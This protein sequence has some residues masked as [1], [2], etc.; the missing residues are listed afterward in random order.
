MDS[1]LNTLSDHVHQVETRFN[2]LRD[3]IISK[4]YECSDCIKSTKQL[5]HETTERNKILENKL[6]NASYEEQEWKDFKAKLAKTSANGMIILNV[7]GEK[8]TTNVETLT[9]EKNTFFTTL[10]SEQWQIERDPDDKSIFIDRNGKIFAHILEYYRTNIVPDYVMND[11]SL[12]ESLIIE[13]EYYR[14][15]SLLEKLGV[16][17]FPNGSLLELAHQKKLNKFYGEIYQRWELIYK[18]SHDGFDANAFHSRCNHQGPTMTI[19]KSKDNYL[20]GGYTAIPWTSDISYKNDTSAFLFTLTNPYNIPSTKYLINPA[21]TEYAVSH[22]SKYGPTFGGGHDVHLANGSNANNNS[23]VNFPYSYL[24]TT[25]KGNN[26]FTGARN[27]TASDI[28]VFK[29]V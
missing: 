20:F 7:G 9:R 8:Y 13:A 25:S 11:K 24:D 5:C 16:V 3:E 2:K 15:H 14:L 19:I 17:Y 28:E 27:F 4:L 23:Y 12:V 6:L 1:D 22:H 10:F 18:A 21:H 29:L 26:T